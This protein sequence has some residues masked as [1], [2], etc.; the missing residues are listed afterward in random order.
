MS[1]LWPILV[2]W[3]SCW[4][5]FSVVYSGGSSL[6]VFCAGSLLEVLLVLPVL[7]LFAARCPGAVRAGQLSSSTT[8]I[9]MGSSPV[10][11]TLS[12]SIG[13]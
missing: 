1:V 13:A 8:A 10:G 11:V 6:G 5:S 4:L 12:R 2:L 9:P 7:P 3:L